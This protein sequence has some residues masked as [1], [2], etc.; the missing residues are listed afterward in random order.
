MSKI[1]KALIFIFSPIIILVVINIIIA[2]FVTACSICHANR[3]WLFCSS[4]GY[5]YLF[6]FL[7]FLPIVYLISFVCWLAYWLSKRRN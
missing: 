5:L 1:K 3:E 4:A 7:I 2:Y 6:S